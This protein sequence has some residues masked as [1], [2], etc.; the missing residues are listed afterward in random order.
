[1]NTCPRVSII[2]PVLN[3]EKYIGHCLI[4]I[5]E[6]DYPAHFVEVIV[7]DNGSTDRTRDIALSYGCKFID[8]PF[9]N[10]AG[11]R[12]LGANTASGSILAFL[13]ADCIVGRDWLKVG[14]V[15]LNSKRTGIVGCSYYKLPENASWI[16]KCWMS[17]KERKEGVVDWVSSKSI[18]VKKKHFLA[19]G[20]FD[21]ALSS[22]EDW[23]FCLRF[24]KNI[25]REI[26][27]SE[28]SAVLHCK[29]RKNLSDFIK[30]EMWYGRNIASVFLSGKFKLKYSKIFFFAVL[31]VIL[32][33]LV[34]GGLISYVFFKKD[35]L[36]ILSFVLLFVPAILIGS[37]KARQ[38]HMVPGLIVLYF[39][40]GMARA[41][42][43]LGFGRAN[44]ARG[45]I[46]KKGI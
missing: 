5:N 18:L 6:L 44:N 35:D 29:C 26:L 10:V 45:I 25:G 1:M 4:S 3:E 7:V 34:I 30:K 2:I 40:Y 33:F 8:A 21:D 15:K 12:N 9:Y 20:G 38:I 27:S 23:D 42:T 17:Q 22:A 39:F 32:S 46:Q 43:V 14:I 37:A 11:L 36:L 28:S 19:I 13:D 16:E 24:K 41:F 31:Y